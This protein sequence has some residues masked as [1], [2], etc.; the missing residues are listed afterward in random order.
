MSKLLSLGDQVPCDAM[1]NAT[2]TIMAGDAKP[3]KTQV[4]HDV[5]VILSHA[6]K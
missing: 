2:T 5:N 4:C 6:T 3:T 1:R